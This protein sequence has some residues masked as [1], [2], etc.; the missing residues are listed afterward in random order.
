LAGL[1]TIAKCSYLIEKN[2]NMEMDSSEF[3]TMRFLMLLQPR[4]ILENL[5]TVGL[6]TSEFFLFTKRAIFMDFRNMSLHITFDTEPAVA[7]FDR[8]C[9][10]FPLVSKQ[11]SVQMVLPA[12][13]EG[14]T[15]YMAG[16]GSLQHFLKRVLH[17]NIG[18]L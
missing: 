6:Q 17:K 4:S 8:A 13:G 14:A 16:K 7:S 11:M 18:S 1:Y 15:V 3:L 2:R 12:I 10:K 5:P 9:K